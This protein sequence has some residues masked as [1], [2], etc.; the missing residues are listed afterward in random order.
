MASLARKHRASMPPSLTEPI[1]TMPRSNRLRRNLQPLPLAERTATA[2]KP[3]SSSSRVIIA[4]NSCSGRRRRSSPAENSAELLRLPA[5]TRKRVQPLR[6]A[7]GGRQ[8]MHRRNSAFV[9]SN[10]KHYSFIAIVVP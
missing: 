10:S 6:A 9:R 1:P 4:S 5:E 8:G 7:V 2:R 3:K